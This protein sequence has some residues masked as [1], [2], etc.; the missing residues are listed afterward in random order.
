MTDAYL[1]K[2]YYDPHHPGG[3]GGLDALYR[4]VRKDG[5]YA[6]TRKQVKTWLQ[7]QE[8]YNLHRPTLR[9]PRKL[10]VISPRVDYQWDCDLAIMI[11]LSKHN[12][13]VRYFLLAIDILS[14]YVWTRPLKTKRGEEVKEAFRSI[15]DEGRKPQRIRTD[16]GTEFTSGIVQSFLTSEGVIYFSTE[17]EVKANYAERA[18]KTLKSKLSRYMTRNN[19]FKWV[20]TLAPITDAYNK[21]V[22]R[23]I[24]TAP[25]SVDDHN[26]AEVWKTSYYDKPLSKPTV[27][28]LEVGDAV[29]LS[30]VKQVFKREYDER[31]TRETFL[32][33]ERRMKEN[34]ACY[35]LKDIQ[36][37]PIAGTFYQNE[38]QKVDRDDDD[39]YKIEEIIDRRR[40]RGKKEVLVK[41][42]GWPKQFNSWIAAD[43]LQDL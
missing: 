9:P 29:R 6:L 34:L 20:S 40:R 7:K 21:A 39:V 31:W 17:S 11:N 26:A 8:T 41:W 4:F 22:H 24:K 2:V 1:E 5:Q 42:L 16:R 19:T 14:R 18:I 32:I 10:R 33:T 12:G 28:K 23:G 43:Q 36:N 25:A 37:E 3:F 27:F 15:F 30:H 38:L 35:K 13:S